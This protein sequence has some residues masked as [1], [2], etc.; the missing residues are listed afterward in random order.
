M[1]EPAL[2]FRRRIL[3]GLEAHMRRLTRQD[4]A[5]AFRHH[6][7]T[8][9]RVYGGL[10]AL[11]E[12][13]DLD[14]LVPYIEQRD[15]EGLRAYLDSRPRLSAWTHALGQIDTGAPS[16]LPDQAVRPDGGAG[17][18]AERSVG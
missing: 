2:I 5:A 16:P 14:A 10:V 4:L 6:V 12:D 18:E 7:E 1:L 15:W 13:P 3:R 11:M 9:V 8:E 17:P